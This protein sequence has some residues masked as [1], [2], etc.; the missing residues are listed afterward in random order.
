MLKN[1]LRVAGWLAVL[2]IVVVSVVPGRLRP[3]VLGE[4]HIEHLAAYL[5][6]SML[7]AAGYPRRFQL[8]LIGVLLSG[9]SGVLETVQLW[10]PGRSSSAAD[11]AAGSLGAWVGVAA[12][13]VFGPTLMDL[14]A[15]HAPHSCRE[16]P[17]APMPHIRPQAGPQGCPSDPH[18]VATR[19]TDTHP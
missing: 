14:F 6:A 19:R 7:L 5:G 1:T 4:K 18:G 16:S 11:F 13:S 8:V 17:G 15:E 3:V 9:C 2:A 12:L 10:I